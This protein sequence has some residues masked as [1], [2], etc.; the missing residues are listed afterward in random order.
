YPEV[1]GRDAR[2]EVTQS[3]RDGGAIFISMVLLFN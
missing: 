2:E 3:S 1:K